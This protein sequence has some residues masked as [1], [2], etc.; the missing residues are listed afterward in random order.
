MKTKI[1]L[2][3]LAFF[4]A[5]IA[6]ATIHEVHVAD[7]HFDPV[8]FDALVGDTV[9]FIWDNG[10]HTT[11][12]STIPIDA[13]PWD[14]PIN[15]ANTIFIYV[16]TVA[17]DYT[18]F[19][20]NHGDQIASFTATGTLPVQ[21]INLQV[22]NTKNNKALI[23]WSTVTEENASYFSIQK[24]TN[25][26]KF[27]EITR[28]DAKGNSSALQQYSYTDNDI[29]SNQFL[30]YKLITVDKDGN[31]NS[32]ATITYKSNS[33]AGKFVTSLSPNPV[34]NPCNLNV[35]FNIDQ[36]EKILIQIFN[37][38]GIA[39][40]Q[41]SINATPGTNSQLHVENLLPGVYTIIFQLH[42]TNDAKTIV[43]Q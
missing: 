38:N 6:K 2:L 17:G 37:A 24:S 30:Y 13:D 20:K 23:S 31:Q 1:F 3:L 27:A 18:Y 12:S 14:E 35:Q 7:F 10:D 11:T 32:S 33:N 43:V 39:V 42:N 40:K 26:K 19:C 8:Q 9:K 34:N 21:L 15:S 16:I 36:T 22:T 41:T 28:V 29:S 25:A 5:L 4:N